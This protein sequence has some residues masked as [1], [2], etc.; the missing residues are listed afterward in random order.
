MRSA[1][2]DRAA[3]SSTT[4]ASRRC[5]CR[6][7]GRTRAIPISPALRHATRPAQTLEDFV[8]SQTRPL[9]WICRTD[10]GE[11]ERRDISVGDGLACDYVYATTTFHDASRTRF[12]RASTPICD[13]QARADSSTSMPRPGFDGTEK[14]PSTIATGSVTTSR[15]IP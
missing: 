15:A 11:L 7:T 3:S 10:V 12:L 5:A 13:V 8:A 6:S 2:I 14:C 9:R 1:V 4:W